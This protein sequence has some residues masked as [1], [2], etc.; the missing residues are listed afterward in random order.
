MSGEALG[1]V[2]TKGLIG[3][4]EAADAMTK[5]ANVTLIGYEKIGSGLVTTLVRGDVGAVKAAVD[6]G[7]AAAEKVGTL[8]SKHII[9]RPHSDV[10]R[11]LPHLG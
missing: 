4:I 9:P 8:V 5:S 3:S 1:M 2:E 7:A 6:A 10:E 11:I